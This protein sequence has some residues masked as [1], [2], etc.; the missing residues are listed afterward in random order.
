MKAIKLRKETEVL[1]KDKKKAHSEG[2]CCKLIT[3]DNI[4]NKELEVNMEHSIFRPIDPIPLLLHSH[5]GLQLIDKELESATEIKNPILSKANIYER[6]HVNLPIAEMG[7]YTLC[8]EN[9]K[10][11]RDPYLTDAENACLTEVYFGNPYKR[12]QVRRVMDEKELESEFMSSKSHSIALLYENKSP[13]KNNPT[14]IEDKKLNSEKIEDMKED[15]DKKDVIITLKK[16]DNVE[17]KPKY[18]IDDKVVEINTKKSKAPSESPKEGM[19]D[20]DM[21]NEFYSS[22]FS[23]ER[24]GHSTTLVIKKPRDSVLESI[25]YEYC[26][27]KFSACIFVLKGRFT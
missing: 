13:Q 26:L 9:K 10:K 14:D 19:S 24:S 1:Y 25:K 15:E 22:C 16:K 2:K 6:A 4:E 7:N 8:L 11:L 12:Q 17:K 5:D 3:A 18:N 23:F 27:T 20:N 21:I